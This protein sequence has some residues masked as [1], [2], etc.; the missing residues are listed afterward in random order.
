MSL[1]REVGSRR[2]WL[3]AAALAGAAIGLLAGWGIARTTESEP[4]LADALART[5]SRIAPA[6]DGLELLSIEYP[7]AVRAGQVVAATEY[8]AARAD[9]RRTR[10]AVER[11]RDE[12]ALLDSSAGSLP[13][14][15]ESLARLVEARAPAAEVTETAR[16]LRADL[17]R[18]SRAR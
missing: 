10:D 18:I 9:L 16:S 4:S 12:L 11:A 3:A 17:R 1:Y 15:L 8:A 7:Q 14:R 2:R 5:Q 6:V 13:G